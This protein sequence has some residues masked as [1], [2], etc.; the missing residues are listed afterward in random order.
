MP[1][2]NQDETKLNVYED[3]YMVKIGKGFTWV[4]PL[5]INNR[6]KWMFRG[7]IHEF[8]SNLEDVTGGSL[9]EGDYYINART[10]GNRSKDSEK[11]IKDANRLKSEYFIEFQKPDKGLS[12]RYGFYAARSFHDSGPEF[13]KDALEW[14]KI[15]INNSSQWLQERYYAS[16]SAGIIY[17]KQDDFENALF[18]FLKTIEFD[19]E[20]IEGIASAMQLCYNRG[21][22]ILVNSLY[23]RFK[24]NVFFP[25]S[26]KL[27]NISYF[28][29]D[30]IEYINSISAYYANDHVGGYDCCK[31]II[32]NNKLSDSEIF[33]TV[34]NLCFYINCVKDAD[35]LELFKMVDNACY[36]NK[37]DV[38]DKIDKLCKFL[39]ERN[40][41]ELIPLLEENT[42]GHELNSLLNKCTE[43][44]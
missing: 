18:Y 41:E 39:F 37:G 42:I 11:Y 28:Y 6:K 16:Y 13:F 40:K 38:T 4:R 17:E 43:D 3:Q 23:N 26:S 21:H 8:L 31:H 1:F 36:K 2:K 24:N 10:I 25:R 33:R 5:V 19:A 22:H 30:R 44:V 9:I 29:N 14:Y 34:S 12:N 15:V 7:I 20:R 27:F 32:L 35:T